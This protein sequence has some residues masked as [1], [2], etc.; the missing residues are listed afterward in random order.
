MCVYGGVH[1][2]VCVY[3][4]SVRVC[5]CVWGGGGGGGGGRGRHIM[6]HRLAFRPTV[7]ILT[8]YYCILSTVL[9]H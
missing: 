3:G 2:C 8:L 1:V 9:I 6:Y 7:K 5:V 4:V